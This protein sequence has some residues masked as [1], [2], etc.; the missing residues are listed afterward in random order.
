MNHQVPRL[1]EHALF[2]VVAQGASDGIVTIDRNSTILFANPAVERIFGYGRGELQGQ[3][4][5]VLMPDYLRHVH[6]AALDR[7]LETGRRH[8]DWSGVELPGLHRDGRIIDLELSFGETVEAGE[9]LFTGVIRNITERKRSDRRWEAQ[10]AVAAALAT[11]D[12]L[13]EASREVLRALGDCLGWNVGVMWLL[14]EDTST[15]RAFVNWHGEP[16][17][18]SSFLESTERTEFE[19][20]VGLPGRVWEHGKA[21]WI[22]DLSQDG[23][24]PRLQVAQKSGLKAAFAFPVTANGRFFAAL[25]FFSSEQREPDN[26]LLN[27]LSSTAAQIG[28][29]VLRMEAESELRRLNA[30]LEDRVKERTAQLEESSRELEAFA[31]SVSHDLRGPLRGIAGFSQLLLEDYQEKLDEGMRGYL[32]RIHRAAGRMGELIDDLLELSRLSK[33][34]LRRETVDLSELALQVLKD[35]NQNDPRRGVECLVQTGV[36][37]KG[38]RQLLRIV[39]ENL[40]GNAWKFSK[41]AESPVIEFGAKDGEEGVYFVRD[42]GAGFDMRY[43]AKLFTP[44]HRLHSPDEFEGTGIGLATVQRVVSRHGGRVWAEAEQGRGATFYFTLG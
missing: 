16:G 3:K 38:D 40:L 43:A 12:S 37:A 2:A 32:L 21:M 31:Y 26:Q 11:T 36:T 34:E 28:Q 14:N 33:S 10:Y 19:R 29:F 22:E 42:N 30:Q 24:F 8:I 41:E 18:F 13:A 25:E 17:S 27:M 23:N 44:F 9:V 35:L 5:T 6:E 39:L 15:L 4:L 7:Y 20:G 1:G